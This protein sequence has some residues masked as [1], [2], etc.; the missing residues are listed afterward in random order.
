[1]KIR[2]IE[3][4]ITGE[5]N[6]SESSKI[7]KIFT[8]DL[9]VISVISKGCKKPKS[10]LHEGSNKLIYGIFDISANFRGEGATDKAVKD[11]INIWKAYHSLNQNAE[12][13]FGP[14]A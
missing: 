12:Q 11:H 7:L 2:K 13:P 6:Y 5:Q 3:G 10:P 4:I 8:R 9:G 14:L 1:M